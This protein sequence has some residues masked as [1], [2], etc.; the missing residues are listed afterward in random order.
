MSLKIEFADTGKAS[1][2]MHGSKSKNLMDRKNFV[3]DIK[4]GKSNSA[5]AEN[6]KKPRSRSRDC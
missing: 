2:D 5:I 3:L 1:S 6:R 4:H